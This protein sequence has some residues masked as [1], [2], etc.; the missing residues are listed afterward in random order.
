MIQ[1][2]IKPFDLDE[3]RTAPTEIWV[4]GLTGAEV[5]GFGCQTGQAEI[6]R[7]AEYEITFLPK[8]KIDLSLPGKLSDR[9]VEAIRSA[10]P[11]DQ[12]GDGKIFIFDMEKAVRIRTGEKDNDAL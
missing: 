2:V 6:Y 3:V 5:R 7:G 11:T 12:I 10:A 1:A 8:I 4:E 9:A